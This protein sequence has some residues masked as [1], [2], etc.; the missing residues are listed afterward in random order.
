MK[1]VYDQYYE[2][3]NLFGAPYPELIEYY[4][5]IENRGRLLDLGC[6]QGR[7]AIPLAKLG[8]SVTGIDNSQVGITQLNQVAKKEGLQLTGIV[9]DI[10]S[11]SD[12]HQFEFI[13]LDSMFHFGKK[14]REKEVNFLK[15][16]CNKSNPSTLITI[17]IQN[18]GNKLCVLNEVISSNIKLR[19]VHQ[20]ELIYRFEDKATNHVTETKYKM[21]TVEKK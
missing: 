18:T 7:D 21:I 8:F 4:S 14:D 5:S 13:L 10:Y 1:I 11:F 9:A 6:G 2:T 16:I 12:F 3:E 20:I 17:C 19:I 15:L